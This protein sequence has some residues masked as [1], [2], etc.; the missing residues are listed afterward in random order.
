MHLFNE[1]KQNKIMAL[2]EKEASFFGLNANIYTI[3]IE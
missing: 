3:L 2:P 1:Y